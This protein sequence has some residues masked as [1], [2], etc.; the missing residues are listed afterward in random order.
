M[1]VST[2]ILWL[3]LGSNGALARSPGRPSSVPRRSG[4]S[5]RG[6][7]SS[8]SGS[9]SGG[10]SSSRKRLIDPLDD[11]DDE[12]DDGA[13]VVGL[14]VESDDKYDD[15]DAIE[16]YDYDSALD[17][18][19]EDFDRRPAA[20]GRSGRSRRGPPPR[21]SS[22]PPPRRPRF[23]DEYDDDV[24]D[25]D[26]PIDDDDYD[27][28]PRRRPAGAARPPP[29]TRSRDRRPPTRPSSSRG[30][31]PRRHENRMVAYSNHPRRRG[32]PPPPVPSTF[33]RGLSALRDRIPDPS[34]VKDT[35]LSA[36]SAAQEKTSQ[37]SSNFYRE[38]K[39]LTSSELEQVML[40]A[41]RPDDAPVKT[42]HVERLVGV[43]YQISGKYDIYDAVLRKLWNKMAEKDLRTKMKSVYVLHRFSIDGGPDHQEALKQ[44]LRALRKT[45]DP[46]RKGSRYFDSKILMGVDDTPEH[47]GT[48]AFLSR[49]AHYVLTRAQTFGGVFNEISLA[50]LPPAPKPQ[51]SSSKK[52]RSG[53]KSGGGR[54]A[55]S[56]S[57]GRP[58]NRPLCEEHLKFA[59]MVLKAGLACA[60]H[61]GE[62]SESTAMCVERVA[63]DLMGLTAAV[64]VAL[65]RELKAGEK[66]GDGEEGEDA[67]ETMDPALVRQW[68]EFYAEELLP[69][70]KKFVKKTSSKLDAYGLYLPS[71]MSASVPQELLERGLKLGSVEESKE[72]Q[73][74]EELAEDMEG[75]IKE[76]TKEPENVG[77][78]DTDQ[79]E[80]DVSM[81][82]SSSKGAATS[83]AEQ[84]EYDEYEY[85]EYDEYDEE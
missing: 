73:E 16:D 8:Y 43:T 34:S 61:D 11:F 33:T 26:D 85:D 62:E 48:R 35:V 51:P 25:Y 52:S 19:D 38:V 2:A 59:K 70:T 68:C 3:F 67:C 79:D 76:E 1:R 66:G 40:K 78:L 72:E 53:S 80:G 77:K 47:Q 84:V 74:A 5:S 17:A 83:P 36:A 22:A 4:G 9:G 7:P 18:A 6:R 39:G 42:K 14:D 12:D 75:G 20:R 10:A 21:G 58:K 28:P 82:M 24:D 63:A 30:P 15:D 69:D 13:P 23:Q 32:P 71:R 49:Y 64:A 65:K 50:L 55:K 29:P 46:K 27:L 56:A 44:R 31:P 45:K 37:L 41:T 81:A 54:G 60:L 57:A